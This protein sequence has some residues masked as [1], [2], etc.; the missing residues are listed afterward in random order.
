M[1]LANFAREARSIASKLPVVAARSREPHEEKHFDAY[2]AL[3]AVWG[4]EKRLVIIVLA[5]DGTV[6]AAVAPPVSS[7]ICVSRGADNPVE[8]KAVDEVLM[9]LGSR[10]VSWCRVYLPPGYR[11]KNLFDILSALIAF[12]V[13]D[14]YGVPPGTFENEA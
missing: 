11:P 5:R 4:G 10:F 2:I 3:P 6:V 8:A 9:E 14:D 1:S 12:G 13:V 7:P